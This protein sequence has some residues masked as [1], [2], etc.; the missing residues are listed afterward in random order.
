MKYAV[1][2]PLMNK[3]GFVANDFALNRN[4]DTGNQPLRLKFH[5]G[6]TDFLSIGLTSLG[7]EMVLNPED[8]FPAG[9]NSAYWGSNENYDIYN[10][11]N[12]ETP[13][14]SGTDYNYTHQAINLILDWA[15]S[16]LTI[17][18]NRI[19]L[20]GSSFGSIGA[21][22]F[23]MTYPERI[24]AIK[25]S[26]GCFNLAF[27]N[28]SNQVCT[29]NAGN[30]NRTTGDQR[31]GT[32][33]SNLAT[34]LGYPVY[35]MLNG[36]WL[37][38]HF[39]SKNYP[40]IYS[41][42]GKRDT[43]VGWTEKTMFYDSVNAAHLGGYYFYDNRTHGGTGST[44]S[45]NNFD[46]FRYRKNNS[47]P[48]FSDC[49]ANE[50]FGNGSAESGAPFGSINGF[51]DWKDQIT[52]ETSKWETTVFLRDLKES[53]G[54]IYP[55]PSSCT[56]SITPR[57]L[58]QFKVTAGD[59]LAWTITHGN[60]VV[61]SGNLYYT[62][63]LIT[64]PDITVFKDAVKFSLI[65]QTLQDSI[66]FTTSSI[67]VYPNPFAFSTNIR[68]ELPSSGKC[69][70]KIYDVQGRWISTLADGEQSE[71]I[72]QVTWNAE[73]PGGA[74]VTTGVYLVRLETGTN[75][76]TKKIIVQR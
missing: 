24:A 32:V 53:S 9:N 72:H 54:A 1:D 10:N 46:L 36:G 31:M 23:A 5:A 51:L 18:S 25:L 7:N 40:V 44:W 35:S 19:Y 8:Y 30:G 75:S 26:V 21:F 47:Y 3:A 59:A 6:G 37:A 29:L 71:G 74:P 48:A 17:D 64:I 15:V 4:N 60:Q 66:G 65:N 68:W 63:G 61:Q 76:E 16:N 62:G 50:D 39:N 45:D 55:A 67:I 52:D 38:N 13:P 56:V 14:V 57:R 11:E 20:D 43:L 22:F 27:Q 69:S 33:S 41:I 58:Q 28:D 49:S 2:K 42:N 73:N 34:N 12:N 70:V